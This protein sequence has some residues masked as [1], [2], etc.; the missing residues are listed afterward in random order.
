VM[1]DVQ[2]DGMIA[3]AKDNMYLN[4]GFFDVYD[5]LDPDIKSL[6]RLM[7]HK[8]ACIVLCTTDQAPRDEWAFAELATHLP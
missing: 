4:Y 1:R 5:V 3:S 6:V 8:I 7:L 2:T